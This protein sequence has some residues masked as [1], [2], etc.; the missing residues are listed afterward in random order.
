MTSD[1]IPVLSQ[2]VSSTAF[3]DKGNQDIA[4][5]KAWLVHIVNGGIV[6]HSDKLPVNFEL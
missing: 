3:K 6:Q 1:L 2:I 5:R 4:Q